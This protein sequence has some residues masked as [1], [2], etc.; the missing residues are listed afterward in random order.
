MFAASSRSGRPSTCCLRNDGS[1][2]GAVGAHCCPGCNVR[3]NPWRCADDAWVCGGCVQCPPAP[4]PAPSRDETCDDICATPAMPPPLA[5]SLPPPLSPPPTPHRCESWCATHALGPAVWQTSCAWLACM[6]CAQCNRDFFIDGYYPQ[7]RGC[8]VALNEYCAAECK[9]YG[10]TV[11]RYDGPKTRWRERLWRCY[12]L[13]TLSANTSA[14]VSGRKYCTRNAA[15]QL[16]TVLRACLEVRAAPPSA[17]PS[18]PER[19][20]DPPAPSP[21]P[22]PPPPPLPSAPPPVPPPD[23]PRAPPH[24]PVPPAPPAPP[25]PPPAPS[26]EPSPPPPPR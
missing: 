3:R 14:Y 11:A 2:G 21:E 18:A 20:D 10:V 13:P 7:A 9:L 26:P 25:A 8:D 16:P 19:D 4:P 12:S 5:V 6:G 17:L 24:P 15:S 22:S 23:P 1:L